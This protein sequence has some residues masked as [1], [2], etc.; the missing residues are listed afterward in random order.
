VSILPILSFSFFVLPLTPSLSRDKLILG[1][2]EAEIAG[3]CEKFATTTKMKFLSFKK[4]NNCLC[5]IPEDFHN[6]S[7]HLIRMPNSVTLLSFLSINDDQ[8]HKH[9][10]VFVNYFQSIKCTALLLYDPIEMNKDSA[11]ALLAD[12]VIYLDRT[13]SQSRVIDLHKIEIQK[14]SSS[15]YC[16]GH[17]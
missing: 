4:M 9:L 3:N 5:A 15:D 10:L 14:L 16:P 7:G 8:C 11:L 1:C 6:L 12:G 13:L 2:R 17:Q